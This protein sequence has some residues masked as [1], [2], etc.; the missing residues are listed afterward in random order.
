[1]R[2]ARWGRS[3]SLDGV[4]LR[5]ATPAQR[6][7]NM[8]SASVKAEFIFQ[9]TPERC[10]FSHFHP[11]RDVHIVVSMPQELHDFVCPPPLWTALLTAS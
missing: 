6:L 2:A 7:G 3:P 8:Y 11:V 9:A 1:M 5:R 4:R 10:I